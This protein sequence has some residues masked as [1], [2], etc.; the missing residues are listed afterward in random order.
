MLPESR[1]YVLVPGAGKRGWFWGLNRDLRGS[2]RTVI[3]SIQVY[4]SKK[5]GGETEQVAGI[6]V[7]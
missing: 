2:I 1:F 3:I 4:F 7:Y 6:T 5:K